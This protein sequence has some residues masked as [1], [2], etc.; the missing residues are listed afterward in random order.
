MSHPLVTRG[1]P[2]AVV[3]LFLKFPASAS[4][5][6]VCM[7]SA[8]SQ[9]G[10]AVNAAIFLMLGV[11]AFMLSLLIAFGIYLYRR[12]NA[13]VPPHVQLAEMIGSEN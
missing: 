1:L 13:P 7:G 2:G 3:A 6:A 9:T 8:D 10:T 11:L 5:C 12:S 4:A